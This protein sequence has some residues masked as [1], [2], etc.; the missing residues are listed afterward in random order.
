MSAVSPNLYAANFSA[1]AFTTATDIF[2]FTPVVDRAVILYGLSLGQT[3]D[4][5]DAAEEVLMIGLFR[6]ATAGATGTAATEYAYNN[7]DASAASTMAVVSTEAATIFP[8]LRL[9]VAVVPTA[10]FTSCGVVTDGLVGSQ[11]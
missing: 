1:S 6:D 11:Y 3:T 8:T 4:L 2:E 10:A 7:A 5:G 9:M